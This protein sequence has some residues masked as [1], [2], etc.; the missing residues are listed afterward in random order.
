MC[1]DITQSPD[2]KRASGFLPKSI[3]TS[4]SSRISSCLNNSCL[5]LTGTISRNK[6]MSETI[7]SPRQPELDVEAVFEE[8]EK[9]PFPVVDHSRGRRISGAGAPDAVIF[10]SCHVFDE[11]PRRKEEPPLCIFQGRRRL[12]WES[13]E[14][15][16]MKCADRS[17]QNGN[18]KLSFSL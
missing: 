8:T 9:K 18:S 12:K 3:T 16:S 1:S 15:S 13:A 4:I 17:A 2:G 10:P 6:S 14:R 11:L 5:M 7:S